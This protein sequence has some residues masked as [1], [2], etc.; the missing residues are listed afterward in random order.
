M[1]P[2][3]SCL[4]VSVA[5]GVYSIG[6]GLE[7]G[8]NRWPVAVSEALPDQGWIENKAKVPSVHWKQ[9]RVFA[10]RMINRPSAMAGD[11]STPSPSSIS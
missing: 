10:A 4:A 2:E 8:S 11:P 3:Q 9:N 1:P 5:C 7:P 6:A